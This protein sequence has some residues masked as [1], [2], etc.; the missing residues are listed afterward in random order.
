MIHTLFYYMISTLI[1]CAHT[2]SATTLITGNGT[3][4]NSFIQPARVRAFDP[5]T[6]N[7]FIGTA[8]GNGAY[9]LSLFAMRAGIF[10]LSFSPLPAASPL[11]NQGIQFLALSAAPGSTN[12]NLAVV[13]YGGY[14]ALF[15]QTSALVTN[16]A[17]TL[18]SVSPQ[19]NDAISA[20]P[21]V[22]SGIVGIAASDTYVFAP[23]RPRGGANF[24]A[25]GSGLAVAQIPSPLGTPLVTLDANTG[26]I[27]NLAKPINGTI[28]QI[29]GD[30][31]P[32]P[33]TFL[34]TGPNVNQVAT[35]WDPLLQR[36]Y[37]G[38]NIQTGANPAAIGKSVIVAYPD[39]DADN[40]ITFSP[41][42]ADTAITGGAVDEIVVGRGTPITFRTRNLNVLHASTGPSYLIVYGNQTV[43]TTLAL[44]GNIFAL[45]LVDNPADPT[46]HGT[47]ANAQA[48]LQN[49]KFV[50]PATAPGQLL[51][52]VSAAALVG[53]GEF[54]LPTGAILSDI[55][56]WGDTVYI[57][58]SESQNS[59][60][61]SG[62]F[63][64]QAQFDA[65]GK[66]LRWTPWTKRAFPA[67]GFV[68][69][70]NPEAASLFT[71]DPVSATV[72]AVGGNN[73]QQVRVATWSPG[74]SPDLIYYLNQNVRGCSHAVLDLDQSTRGFEG[75]TLSRYALF[76]GDRQVIFTR[77]SQAYQPTITSP[78][79]VILDF[80]SSA[81]FL[82]TLLPQG[83]GPVY[84]LEYSRQLTGTTSNYFFAGT[85]AGLYVFAA[86]SG[87]GFDV[88]NLSTLSSS[89]FTT[90]IWTRVMNIPGAVIDIKT[91]GNVLYVLSYSSTSLQP[92]ALTVYRIPFAPTIAQMFAPA[93]IYTIA[94]SRVGSLSEAI[95]FYKIAIIS[96]TDSGQLPDG[97][98]EQLVLATNNGLYKSST[99]GGVQAAINQ[100]AANWTLI[101]G[102]RRVTASLY[103]GISI[104]DNA[105]IPISP[106]STVFP[107]GLTD[108]GNCGLYNTSVVRQLA[109]T[110]STGPFNFV[111]LNFITDI[112]NITIDIPTIYDFW[113]DG[114]RRYAIISYQCTGRRLAVIPYAGSLLGYNP[115][116]SF[117]ALDPLLDTTSD[118]FWIRPIGA[119]GLLLASTNRGIIGQS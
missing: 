81:N 83:A 92:M 7:L 113:T 70:Q 36:L 77:V 22:T 54:S 73:N 62:V 53:A 41:I 68:N 101:P 23:V 112:P 25:L 5:V 46:V 37:L 93:N 29:R 57:V 12:A 75:N 117:L 20:P 44:Q 26:F 119:T 39:P 72:V 8:P 94:Q 106:P 52:D 108:S 60:T 47:L 96:T 40:A 88:N 78:Q 58:S 79:E 33:A 63:Y 104:I 35:Y 98:Q 65:Q 38:F 30:T 102:S 74:V 111:P 17:R 115:A 42:A 67:N 110:A 14:N 80:S 32:A 19:F 4:P 82:P 6:G 118:V 31:G 90:N 103:N 71:V 1:M 21:A 45:P 86:P 16:T 11:V 100:V 76:G 28:T 18:T 116:I 56:V 15:N 24:G 89:P 34:A 107:F 43:G 69:A 109:G 51:T 61:E 114:T 64:S 2:L 48:P 9:A 49:F 87:A 3:V 10:P 59:T 27:G 85:P 105:S 55:F 97:S 66:I 95:F 91:T 13:I 84:A 99:L 50:V